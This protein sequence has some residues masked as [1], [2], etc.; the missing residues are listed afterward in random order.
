MLQTTFEL[1]WIIRTNPCGCNKPFLQRLPAVETFSP[2][3]QAF[4]KDNTAQEWMRL[5]VHDIE[6]TRQVTTFL[7]QM[8]WCEQNIQPTLDIAKDYAVC[9]LPELSKI[10]LR[11]KKKAQIAHVAVGIYPVPKSF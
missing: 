2:K 10:P 9:R 7:F 8:N 3:N 1:P 11:G 5:S 6:R 4:L